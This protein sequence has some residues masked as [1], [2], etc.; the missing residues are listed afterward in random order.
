MFNGKLVIWEIFRHFYE[1][2]SNPRVVCAWGAHSTCAAS[3]V[4]RKLEIHFIN[5]SQSGRNYLGWQPASKAL[6][7][8]K[9]KNIFQFE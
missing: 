2:I 3:S 9:K 1:N 5:S 6:T 4:S 7:E 8:K